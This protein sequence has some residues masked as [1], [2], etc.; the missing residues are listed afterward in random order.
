MTKSQQAA[1]TQRAVRRRNFKFCVVSAAILAG[2]ASIFLVSRTN[3]T[4]GSGSSDEQALTQSSVPPFFASEEAA[5]PL[6]VTLSPELVRNTLGFTAYQVAQKIP[7]V[8]AQQPCYC[9]CD[10]GA[11][12]RSLLDCYRDNHAAG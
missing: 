6:P 8:L 11:G 9:S 2:I 5:R 4:L 3:S 7:G 12:H 1:R 10:V